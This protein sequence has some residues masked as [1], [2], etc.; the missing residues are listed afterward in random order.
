MSY[1]KK[2]YITYAILT[3]FIMGTPF[4]T[5]DGNHLL[6]L[7]FVTYDFHFLGN[8]YNMNEFFIMPFL[9]M[10][11]FIGIF[12]MTSMFGRVWCGWGCPQTIFRVIYRD[13]IET[14]LL[15]LR[16]IK[17]KQKDIN[18]N[19]TSTK[20]KKYIG[21]LLWIILSFVI[22]INFMLYF[23]PPEDFIEYMKSP[24]DHF[25]L[26]MFILTIVV[27]LVYDIVFMK[28]HFCTY[29]CPYSRIQSVLYDNNTK[30]VVYN[31]NRGGKI[32]PNNEKSIFNVKQWS[33]NEECTTCEACVKVCPTHID[34]R[35]GLQV[36]CIN[37]LECSDACSSV[38]GKLGKKSLIYWGS[39][40]SVLLE[41]LE[42]FLNPRNLV[43][44]LSLVVCILFT[45]YFMSEKEP[46]LVNINKN[47]ELYKID[48]NGKVVNNYLLTIYNSADKRYTFDIEV[49][50]KNISIKRYN[51]ITLNPKQTRKTVLILVSKN[52]I[53]TSK[54]NLLFY[55]KENKEVKMEKKILFFFPK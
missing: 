51:P 34:I 35:K 17:N 53:N 46:F 41:K 8:V 11:L 50:D 1:S 28:E 16:R 47:T 45:A 4:I 19:K 26:V 12:A 9:L 24:Q 23:V 38:M 22:A 32:Y 43:Y 15:K 25:F 48:E 33:G 18:Y 31:H 14:F 49:L 40:N 29:V 42:K 54:I 55:A 52:K 37:C 7:S 30:Q 2:R 13:L 39:T 3:I 20:I 36:E 10:F 5:I 6:L 21:L 44:M 27:F